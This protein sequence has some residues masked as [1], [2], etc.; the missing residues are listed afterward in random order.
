IVHDPGVY[1]SAIAVDSTGVAH[2]VYE[3]DL[4]GI[5]GDFHLFY[6]NGS[7]STFSAPVEIYPN[8]THGDTYEEKEPSLDY[9]RGYLHLV[10]SS[11]KTGDKEIYYS[12]KPIGR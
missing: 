1:A 3:T 5:L 7:G 10:F 6:V 2:I 12:Y 8:W 11:G 4:K 9:A